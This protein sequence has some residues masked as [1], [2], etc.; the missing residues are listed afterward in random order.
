[1]YYR[2]SG[3]TIWLNTGVA[4]PLVIRLLYILIILL[5]PNRAFA[6]ATGLI[7]IPTAEILPPASVDLEVTAQYVNFNS[8]LGLQVGLARG[9][10]SGYDLG[11]GDE[12]QPTGWNIKKV[13]CWRNNDPVFAVGTQNIRHNQ[14]IQPYAV[15]RV[16]VYDGWFHAG[17]IL[18]DSQIEPMLGYNHDLT[19]NLDL[20]VDF[21]GGRENGG[22]AGIVIDLENN[23]S[24]TA[25]YLRFNSGSNRNSIYLA[26]DWTFSLHKQ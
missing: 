13:L 26:V 3:G 7:I 16:P 18:T 10:E 6:A 20:Q 19:P 23:L 24:I 1:V 14:K 11:W 9:L 8:T 2:Y 25:A 5:L 12:P 21:I 17:A 22:S 4:S 15:G